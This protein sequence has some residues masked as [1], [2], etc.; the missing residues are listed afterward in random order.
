MQIKPHQAAHIA[1]QQR[2]F[3]AIRLEWQSEAEEEGSYFSRRF[4]K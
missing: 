4:E 3:K 2:R 1:E